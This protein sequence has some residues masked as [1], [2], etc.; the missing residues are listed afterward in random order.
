MPAIRGRVC[1]RALSHALVLA[2]AMLACAT[3]SARGAAVPA[4]FYGVNSGAGLVDDPAQR[5]AAFQ[6]MRAGGLSQVRVDASWSSIEPAAPVAG[7]HTYVWAKYD[8]FVA[9]LARNDLRWYPMLGYSAPWATSVTGNPFS[10]PE[11]DGAF[12]SFV[13]AFAQR[14]GEAGSFWAEHPELPKLPT[15]VYGVWNEPSKSEFWQG[16]QAT[17]ARYMSLYQA[18]R[19][20]IRSVDPGARVATAGLLDSGTVDGAAYLRAMLDSVPA[21]A[22]AQIDAIGWHPYVGGLDE[23]LASVQGARTTLDQYGLDSVP[24]EIS[25]VGWHTGFTSEQRASAMRGMAA[26]LPHA[27]LNVARLMPYVWAGDP[28][29]QITNGDGSPGPVSGAYLAGIRDARGPQPIARA[30]KKKSKK[31]ARAA[32][33]CRS[34]KRA[35]ARKSAKAAKRTAVAARAASKTKTKATRKT[36]KG[37]KRACV[38]K[39]GKL[40]AARKKRALRIKAMAAKR[41]RARA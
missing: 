37:A 29:W 7:V 35:S 40:T 18:A 31:K 12:A 11:G 38:S 30:V 6:T 2:C 16:A 39:V 25:E 28:E 4:E 15:T 27:G 21:A 9:D 41:S 34:G 14:Y 5:P 10:A 32:K 13:T 26:R 17:P 22:R 33:T 20:A 8:L 36:S 24:I 3:V 19:D 1:A 23:A